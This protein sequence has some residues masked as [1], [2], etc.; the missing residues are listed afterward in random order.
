MKIFLAA[1]LA[2]GLA[3]CAST[4]TKVETSQ[5]QQF[6][7]GVTT[8]PEVVAALGDPTTVTT[9]SDGKKSAV[10]TYAQS[11]IRPES[12]IPYVGLFAGGADVKSTAVVF[13]FDSADKLVDYSTSM[14][15]A[16]AGYGL[17]AK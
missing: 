13:R 1:A 11:K 12:F 10:Y 9:D 15:N 6:Q 8:Y 7:K 17:E 3:G 16:G 14:S 5:I 4:G 2:L